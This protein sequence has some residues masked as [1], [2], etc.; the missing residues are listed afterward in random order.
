MVRQNEGYVR[1]RAPILQPSVH[2][3]AAVELAVLDGEDR[4]CVV[5]CLGD[6]LQMALSWLRCERV[7]YFS[8]KLLS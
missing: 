8:S 3:L 7:F 4:N 5:T 2:V 6:E 1:S